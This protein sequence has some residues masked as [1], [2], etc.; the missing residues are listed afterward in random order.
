M[1]FES[2]SV[3]GDVKCV[4]IGIIDDDCKENNESFVFSIGAG[5]DPSVHIDDS[6]ADVYIIDDDGKL[7]IV[8]AIINSRK[9]LQLQYKLVE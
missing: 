8:F 2:G 4:G 7:S 9:C 1:T 6:R 5:G 3:A